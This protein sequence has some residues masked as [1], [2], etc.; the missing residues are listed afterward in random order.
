MIYFE[1][2]LLANKRAQDLVGIFNKL[3]FPG[4]L[5]FM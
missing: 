3:N 2:L 4:L 5:T 1:V